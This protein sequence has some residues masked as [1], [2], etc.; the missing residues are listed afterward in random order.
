VPA[1]TETPLLVKGRVLVVEDD[2]NV[3]EVVVRYLEREGFDAE[4]VADGFTDYGLGFSTTNLTTTLPD[5]R[6]IKQTN[7]L[8]RINDD[9][10]TW[11]S[12]DRVL[13]DDEI[14]DLAPVKVTRV[15]PK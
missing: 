4:A 15:K 6:T 2:A 14:P 3:S 9:T 11:Q 1:S 12:V 13:G 10:V 7:V 8:R 5:G